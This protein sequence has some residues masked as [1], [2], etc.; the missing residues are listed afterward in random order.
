M[1]IA[2]E[3][4]ASADR[5]PLDVAVVFVRLSD[6]GAAIRACCCYCHFFLPE[7]FCYKFCNGWAAVPET[8]QMQACHVFARQT[9]KPP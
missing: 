4:L 3:P 7:S 9:Q 5:A 8:L 6:P 1:A 2:G